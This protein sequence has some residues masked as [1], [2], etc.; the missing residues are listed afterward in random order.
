MRA[1]GGGAPTGQ[2]VRRARPSG[3]T[4]VPQA[5]RPRR[6]GA[7][8]RTRRPHRTV[9]GGR[10]AGGRAG[11]RCPTAQRV[12]RAQAGA[13]SLGAAGAR[14]QLQ[15]QRLRRARTHARTHARKG[16]RGG[17]ASGALPRWPPP[18]A[19]RSPRPRPRG[20]RRA[21]P[22]VPPQPGRRGAGAQRSAAQ[23]SAAQ[24]SAGQRLARPPA[25]RRAPER[26]SPSTPTAPLTHKEPL[27][28]RVPRL[29]R[30]SAR[31]R[32]HNQG[33]LPTNSQRRVCSCAACICRVCA[34]AARH[35]DRWTGRQTHAAPCAWPIARPARGSSAARW[36]APLA[37][38]PPRAG[39][40]AHPRQLPPARAS[41]RARRDHP[42]S[43]KR[44]TRRTR[45]AR[46]RRGTHQ[47]AEI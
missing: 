25:A 35:T 36:S 14:H 16:G 13:A 21:P 44:C 2:R 7:R 46:A 6:T 28:L 30:T 5:W 42:P 34:C 4:T 33:R 11:G 32:A 18:V 23:R 1:R 9:P 47:G 29:R 3:A 27:Q 10:P 26:V 39:A 37:S 20:S 12:G 22:L 40:A 17:R 38:P 8:A 24:R 19:T 43:G 31:V 45:A 41:R 15:P